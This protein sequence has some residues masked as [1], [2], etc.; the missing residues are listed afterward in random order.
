[1]K[2][3]LSTAA[4]SRARLRARL[5]QID[6]LVLAEAQLRARE[7]PSPAPPVLPPA[8]T[9]TLPDTLDPVLREERAALAASRQSRAVAQLRADWDREHRRAARLQLLRTAWAFALRTTPDWPT[10]GPTYDTTPAV[11]V[12]A[13]RLRL[14]ERSVVLRMMIAREPHLATTLA[15]RFKPAAAGLFGGAAALPASG[16]SSER[17]AR[18]LGEIS[19]EAKAAARPL[20]RERARDLI[21]ARLVDGR[22]PPVGWWPV[23]AQKGGRFQALDEGAAA[24]ADLAL[25]WPCLDNEGPFPVAFDLV[26]VPLDLRPRTEGVA[27]LLVW[28]GDAFGLADPAWLLRELASVGRRVRLHAGVP[29]W[30]EAVAQ[31]HEPPA[32]APDEA[33]AQIL[34]TLGRESLQRVPESGADLPEAPLHACILD[35]KGPGSRLLLEAAPALLCDDLEQAEQVKRWRKALKLEAEQARTQ[36][37]V[38]G[39]AA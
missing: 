16:L 38:P 20:L 22:P 18:W 14:Y 32:E 39:V 12:A 24:A 5:D 10:V 17:L 6:P 2:P 23:E 4:E 21:T 35:P 19:A 11:V 26:A 9:P 25:L 28:R 34:W 3:D 30:L 13:D 8:E 31:Q 1:M 15:E 36:I 29:A 27:D 7:R 33:A 37:L